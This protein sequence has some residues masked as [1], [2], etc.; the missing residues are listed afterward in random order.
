MDG[1]PISEHSANL[2]RLHFGLTVPILAL[3]IITLFCRFYVRIRPRWTLG[4]DDWCIGIGTVSVLSS[5]S[6]LWC[7]G[8]P[9]RPQCGCSQFGRK[10][11]G[12]LL[13]GLRLCEQPSSALYL[14]PSRHPYTDS[15]FVV[16]VVVAT[17]SSL[18]AI[19][20]SHHRSEL[21]MT[22]SCRRCSA[23]SAGRCLPKR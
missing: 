10:S 7:P 16:V 8:R 23:L 6:L 22:L 1:I 5:R 9:S 18:P 21:T 11:C 2:A 12:E 15:I 4:L 20:F 17:V 3:C 14:Q 19:R 13:V